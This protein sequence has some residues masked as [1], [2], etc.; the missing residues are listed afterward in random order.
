M[1]ERESEEKT[2][3]QLYLSTIYPEFFLSRQGSKGIGDER[4]GREVRSGIKAM[5]NMEVLRVWRGEVLKCDENMY[6]TIQYFRANLLASIFYLI[7]KKC[8][9]AYKE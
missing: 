2:G 6:C 3:I 1:S 4:W 7:Q 9:Y 8:D 5:K